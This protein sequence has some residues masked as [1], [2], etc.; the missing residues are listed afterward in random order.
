MPNLPPPG[1]SRRHAA[2]P[3][4]HRINCNCGTPPPTRHRTPTM[5]RFGTRGKALRHE[6]ARGSGGPAHV[7]SHS[8]VARLSVSHWTHACPSVAVTDARDS[9]AGRGGPRAHAVPEHAQ[10][11]HLPDERERVRRRVQSARPDSRHPQ[12]VHLGWQPVTTGAAENPTLT[13]VT[14]AIR[15]AD[16]VAD[17]LGKGEI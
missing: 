15:Q 11:G 4:P 6:R 10:H 8:A 5:R 13:I 2:D 3:R 9:R 7:R 17:Q 14:L 16:H 12:S 1:L